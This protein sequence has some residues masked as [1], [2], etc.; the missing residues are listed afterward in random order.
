MGNKRINLEAFTVTETLI[1]MVISAL[2]IGISYIFVVTI[3]DQVKWYS[4]TSQNTEE[5]ARV[6]Y[7]LNRKIFEANAIELKDGRLEIKSLTD[8]IVIPKAK[9]YKPSN[10]TLSFSNLD[11]IIT[12]NKKYLKID[13]MISH[14][15]GQTMFPGLHEI[16]E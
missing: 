7:E 6:S 16:I 13:F 4:D 2:V 12:E 10:E 3:Y 11:T 14:A 9:D 8:T 1:S 15:Y 5:F